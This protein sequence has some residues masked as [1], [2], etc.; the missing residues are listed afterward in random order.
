MRSPNKG[1]RAAKYILGGSEN[2][3]YLR[4]PSKGSYK[5]TIRVPVRGSIRVQSFR[6]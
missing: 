5:G 4:V 1:A 2:E 3:G 6:K